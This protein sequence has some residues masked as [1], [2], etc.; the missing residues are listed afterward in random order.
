MAFLELSCF[1]FLVELDA[2]LVFVVYTSEQTYHTE[3][4]DSC[5]YWLLVTCNFRKFPVK[6][7]K[8]PS[9]ESEHIS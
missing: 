7:V 9:A 5:R 3:Q 1:R 8:F 6:L 2:Q 4:L